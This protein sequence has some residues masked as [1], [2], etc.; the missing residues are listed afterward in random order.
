L[1]GKVMLHEVANPP[2]LSFPR[3][4]L[5]T[6]CGSAGKVAQNLLGPGRFR[7]L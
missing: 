5:F 7:S 1:P 6:G 3:R 2:G 4:A